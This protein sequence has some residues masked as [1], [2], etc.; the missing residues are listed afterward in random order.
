MSVDMFLDSAQKQAENVQ[1]MCASHIN[2]LENMRSALTSFVNEVDLKGKA[3]DSA[4]IYFT[5]MYD[6]IIKGLILIAEKLKAV[7]NHFVTQYMLEVD[8]NSLREE[9]LRRMIQELNQQIS[10]LI[11]NPLENVDPLHSDPKYLGWMYQSQRDDI[12]KQLDDLLAYDSKTGGVFQEVEELLVSVKKGLSEVESGQAFHKGQ[13]VFSY[14]NLDRDWSNT[15][16][17][18]WVNSFK[19]KITTNEDGTVSLPNEM[20][21]E[22]AQIKN[23]KGRTEKEKINA[24][25]GVYEKYLYLNNKADFDYYDAIR[26]KYGKNTEEEKSADDA[27][28]NQLQLS[29]I[30]IKA[31]VGRMGDDLVEISGQGSIDYLKFKD[32]VDTRHPLDLKNR[33]TGKSSYSIWGRRWDINMSQDYLGNYLFG[34]YGQGTLKF[35]DEV[36]K[37]G[38]GAAQLV[39]DGGWKPWA[40]GYGFSTP[41][42]FIAAPIFIHDGYG[43]NPGDGKMIQEGI[44]AY[45]KNH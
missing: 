25:V 38:A 26:S 32:M 29:G 31:V 16:V 7:S 43:D 5:V 4:K 39:S 34:Y 41:F 24:I 17:A 21:R 33:E 19:D 8:E 28:G 13:G 37:I 2:G 1:K 14:K 9:E 40:Y 6:P 27:L 12:Q 11:Q 23:D 42:I 35:G 18:K 45:K 30:D 36:L 20:E 3:Y 22:I 15:I 44:N 10:A